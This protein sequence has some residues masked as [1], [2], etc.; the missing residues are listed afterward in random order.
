[1]LSGADS[2]IL[3]GSNGFLGNII[4]NR[5]SLYNPIRVGRKRSD[6]TADLSKDIPDLK[7]INKIDCVIHAAGKAHMVPHKTEEKEM[8]W[9]VNL[10]GTKNLCKG[11]EDS[12]SLPIDFVFISSV[13]VYGL[14]EGDNIDED[15]PL[16]GDSD[17]ARSKIEAEQWLANWTRKHAIRLLIL[18]LP[19]VAGPR[20]P[21][22]LGAMIEGIKNGRYFRIGD[23]KAK[24]SIVLATDV[25]E[26]ISTSR[27]KEGIY[28]LTDGY[29]PSFYELE[30]VIA[31]QL[32]KKSP[33]SIPLPI[34]RFAAKVGD[35]FGDKFP[36]NSS[37]ILKMTN[38][39]TF[40][41]EKARK[42]LGWNPHKVVDE[43]KIY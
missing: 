12:R 41:D 20:P 34:A 28:N 30:E 8:F 29:H 38:S 1:M 40:S 5:F 14:E 4:F 39:L 15:H 36:L 26:V 33:L 27:G 3:T 11:L 13:S 31:T 2:V 10:E 43:F 22:N 32:G 21:G 17:Y 9:K 6:I 24:K 42:N 23:G 35:I 25:A 37:R 16:N 18:R 7:S 19:L